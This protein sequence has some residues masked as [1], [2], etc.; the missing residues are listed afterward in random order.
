VNWF[1]DG[2]IA[3]NFPL[4]MFDGWAPQRPTFGI[5][6]CDAPL[7]T[8]LPKPPQLAARRRARQRARAGLDVSVTDVFRANAK[9]RRDVYP[10]PADIHDL[11]DLLLGMLDTARSFRD[12]EQIGMASYRERVAQVYLEPDE[13]GLNLSMNKQTLDAVSAKGAQAAV[14]LSQLDFEEHRWVRTMLLLDHLE[15]H[16]FSLEPA[17]VPELGRSFRALCAKAAV[18]DWYLSKRSAAW[19]EEA[20]RRVDALGELV[21]AWWKLQA[22]YAPGAN[23]GPGSQFFHEDPARPGGSLRVTSEV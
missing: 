12:N 9:D 15:R 7:T 5:N 16:V 11:A 17:A 3:A 8:R 22:A 23:V 20:A 4:G 18:S 13:G 21:A 1:S 6:L 19:N 14:L 10:D 2:G